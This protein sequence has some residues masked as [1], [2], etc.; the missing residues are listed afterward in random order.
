MGTEM[1]GLEM[2][3]QHQPPAQN[4]PHVNQPQMVA[5]AQQSVEQGYPYAAAASTTVASELKQPSPLSD[6]DD[7]GFIA[8]DATGD[9]KRKTS[10]WQRMKWTDNI[11]RILLLAVYSIVDEVGSEGNDPTSKKKAG[12]LL[13][14]RGKWKSVSRAMMEKGFYVSPQQCEDKF[15]DLNKRYKR[16]N[17]ILGKEAACGVVENQS[18]LD[19]MDL[20]PKMKK[21]VRKLLNSK[22]LFFKEM[23]AYHDS[24]G[25]NSTAA[26]AAAASG[27]NHS[28]EGAVEKSHTQH[29][30]HSLH[31][32]DDSQIM[33][34]SGGAGTEISTMGE[35]VT[36]EEGEEEDEDESDEDEDEDE[37]E[38]GDDDDDDEEETDEGN[39]ITQNGHG[40]EEVD[41]HAVKRPRREGHSASIQQLNGEIM[42]VMQDRGKTPWEKAQWLKLRLLQLEEKQMNHQ[43]QAFEIEKQRLKWL[44]F[45]SKKEREMERAKLENE[46]RRLEN[47]RLMLLVREKEMEL[48]E[49][50]RHH[51]Q[52]HSA[53]KRNDPSSVMDRQGINNMTMFNSVIH[54]SNISN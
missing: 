10:L 12:A 23:C 27:T 51:P 44:E 1:L 11:V 14:K 25:H 18:L 6:D 22:H 41:E 48:L 26:A 50:L 49:V 5:F 45:S 32:T 19:S 34:N 20:S 4:P 42:S 24:C 2:Q 39:A 47:E 30:Q 3:S 13:Q 54:F 16:I 43:F 8:D 35:R 21:E 28:P 52:H 36:G 33:A 29:Q 46:G 37:D 15:N 40:H 9:G 17:D 53:N 38:D 7:H 31:S